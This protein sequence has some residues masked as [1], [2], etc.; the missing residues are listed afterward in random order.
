MRCRDYEDDER[1]QLRGEDRLR[2]KAWAARM[3][4]PWE[5]T[6]ADEDAI[7]DA[8]ELDKPDYE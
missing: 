3:K 8:H 5:R 6:Q 7:A 2:R 4:A 1:E